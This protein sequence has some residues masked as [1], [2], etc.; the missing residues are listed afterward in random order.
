MWRKRRRESTLPKEVQPESVM[1]NRKEQNVQSENAVK[2]FY[3]AD[4]V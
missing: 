1:E 4:N 2:C 3:Q